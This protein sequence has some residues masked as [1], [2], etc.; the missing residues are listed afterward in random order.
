MRKNKF[1]VSQEQTFIR[2]CTQMHADEERQNGAEINGQFAI[3][4][5]FNLFFASLFIC[6]H[7]RIKL[8]ESAAFILHGL[9]ARR[10]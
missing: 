7:L 1:A 5:A 10:F 3:R 2:R 4:F 9:S 6:V 8:F